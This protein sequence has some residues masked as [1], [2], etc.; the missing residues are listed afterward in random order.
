VDGDFH[1]GWH[2]IAKSQNIGVLI[3]LAI[4]VSA[5]PITPIIAVALMTIA[6]TW[7]SALIVPWTTVLAGCFR[8][9]LWGEQF[10]AL[11][12][13]IIS[14]Q[15]NHR[16]WVRNRLAGSVL[17]F[18]AAAI[19]SASAAAASGFSSGF[20]GRSF[21]LL[22]RFSGGFDDF[23]SFRIDFN[24]RGRLPTTWTTATFAGARGWRWATIVLDFLLWHAFDVSK[25]DRRLDQALHRIKRFGVARRDDHKGLT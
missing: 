14:A 15:I 10:K 13:L 2:I 19:A 9:I 18:C 25:L 5:T 16:H 24:L 1:K 17:W 23:S 4:P 11:L 21:V 6:A 22:C 20:N 3:L 7:P 12:T 8:S